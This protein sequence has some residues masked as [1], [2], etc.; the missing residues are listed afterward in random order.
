MLLLILVARLRIGFVVHSNTS[1]VTINLVWG[2]VGNEVDYIQIHLMLL[3][4]G[5]RRRPQ[6]R[7]LP[8]QIH[9]MLLLI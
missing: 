6:M 5:F 1:H 3:L 4:I 2:G 7:L 8:I 9:L